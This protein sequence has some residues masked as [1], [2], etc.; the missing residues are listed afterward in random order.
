MRRNAIFDA[1]FAGLTM[2]QP[3]LP[4]GTIDVLLGAPGLR[5]QIDDVLGQPGLPGTV[6]TTFQE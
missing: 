1:G 2:L 6:R 3:V 4:D 5:L